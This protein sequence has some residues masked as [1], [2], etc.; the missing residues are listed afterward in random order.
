MFLRRKKRFDFVSSHSHQPNL[1]ERTENFLT[2]HRIIK[3]KSR[4]RRYLVMF[5]LVLIIIFLIVAI[6]LGVAAFNI[7]QRA[8]AIS[9]RFSVM[10]LDAGQAD[11][12]ALKSEI[13]QTQDDLVVIKNN[14]HSAGPILLYP[15]IGRSVKS[16]EEMIN[17]TVNLL[18]GYNEVITVLEKFKSETELDRVALGF[19]T[20]EEKKQLL[21]AISEN[22]DALEKAR[23]KVSQAQADLESI[24]TADLTGLGGDK[25]REFNQVLTKVVANSQVALPIFKYLP[26]L[27]GYQTPKT[28]LLIFQN[29][30]EMRPTGGF[31]GSYGLLTV[32]DGDIKN[33]FIDDVYNLDKYSND[34]LKIAAP[35]PMQAYNNQK[36]LF[37]RDANWSPDWPTSAKTILDF[38]RQESKNA[39]MVTERVDGVIAFTPQLIADF[40]KVTGPITVQGITFNNQNFKYELEKFVEFD[41][42]KQGIEV[43]QRKA[44]LG[45]LTKQLI[46]RLKKSSPTQLLTLWETF[47]QNIDQKNI[48][49]YLTD[50]NLQNYFVAQ[51]WSGNVKDY[52]GDYWLIIDSNLAALKT[53]QAITQNIGYEVSVNSSGELIGKLSI[54]Y[55]HNSKPVKD[56]ISRYRDYVRIYVPDKT[57]FLKAYTQEKGKT[58]N[59]ELMKDLQLTNELNKRVAATF[60]TVEPLTTKTLVLEYR[61]PDNLKKEYEN[62]VYKLLV[63]KQ[64]GA[65]GHQLKINLNFNH[66]IGAYH[67]AELPSHFSAGSIGW[68]G[69]LAQ[70]QEYTIK[71]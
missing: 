40:L 13:G 41:Y 54:T 68:Q 24:N 58:T 33:I 20:P 65:S 60:L 57:W 27:L 64:P 50:N 9:D 15:D 35:W 2:E 39:N 28:Y 16:L 63:Q 42:S 51:N 53:D 26:E 19:A 22:S 32:L 25:I 34:K 5:F 7:Y 6:P 29:D 10:V 38:Y 17:A 67:S 11:F 30:M 49:V 37:L 46:E 47:K 44:I 69:N 12:S 56:L 21:K 36:Y 62:G 18:S 71:F 4:R 43:G 59:L 52:S 55:Q 45:E 66:P 61:L 1:G 14:L 3:P 70:D 8:S 48:L 23:M 31:I